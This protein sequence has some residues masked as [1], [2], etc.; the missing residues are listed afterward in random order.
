MLAVAIPLPRLLHTPPVTNT[1]RGS[2]MRF[3]VEVFFLDL[4][5]V[6]FCGAID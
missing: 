5:D 1:K 2:D 4:T 6:L 3:L